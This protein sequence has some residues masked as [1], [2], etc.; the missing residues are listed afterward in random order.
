M[1]DCS[2]L[3]KKRGQEQ[4]LPRVF[5]FLNNQTVVWRLCRKSPSFVMSITHK[6]NVLGL[7]LSPSSDTAPAGRQAVLKVN[8]KIRKR[9]SDVNT[10]KNLFFP[11]LVTSHQLLKAVF[12]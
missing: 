7:F 11:P 10:G 9:A 4:L 12:Y 3:D 2:G 6:Q 8:L 1:K 5:P